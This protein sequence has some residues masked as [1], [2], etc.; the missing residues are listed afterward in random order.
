MENHYTFRHMDATE[1]IK[2]HAQNASVKL[3][4]FVKPTVNANW[5]FLVEAGEHKAELRVKGPHVDYFVEARTPN[6]YH[7][8]DEAVN[9]M[10]KQLKK[11]KEILKNH[12]HR[13]R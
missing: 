5:I 2:E 11:H 12:L 1:A 8:I 4:K 3:E 9:K 6:L 13:D 10:E 7:S